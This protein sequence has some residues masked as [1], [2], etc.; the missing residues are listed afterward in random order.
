VP[1]FFDKTGTL[2]Q[3][4][5]ALTGWVGDESTKP[6]VRAAE[7]GSAHPVAAAL[8]AGVEAEPALVARDVTHELGGGVR[9]R[10]G[11]H[12]VVVGSP[13][14]VARETGG[15]PEWAERAISAGAADGHTPVVIA[16]DGAVRS[17]A[18]LGDPVRPDAAKALADLAAL[19]HRL[20]V[21]SGDHPEVVT[22]VARELG[23]D[24]AECCGGVTPEA[25][26]ARIERAVRE[27]G[28]IMV[29]DGANDAAALS[30]ATVGV[31]VHGGA[32]ASLAAA[33]VFTTRGGVTPVVDLVRGARRT[34]AVIRRNVAFSLSYNL[35]AV[36]LA[37]AGVIGPLLAAVL[38][39]LSSIAVVMSSYRA[40][41]FA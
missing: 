12:H 21:I 38:M 24:L 7:L 34:L 11:E 39:P 37:M 18:L 35:V 32:E 20:A 31:A 23:T 6:L 4:K 2:T 30:A 36:T 29:G 19:G 17:V 27:G 22:A 15:V 10:V 26:L 33:D 40:R 1:V 8:V 13:R 25:K 28:A 5:L 14:Y 16:T 9:A 3:G 41:M